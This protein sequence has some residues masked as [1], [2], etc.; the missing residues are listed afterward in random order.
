[1][2]NGREGIAFDGKI[3]GMTIKSD[4][5]MSFM[6]EAGAVVA[7]V[8]RS[9]KRAIQPGTKTRELDLIAEEEIDKLGAKS[10]FKGYT[11]GGMVPFPATIC[12]SVND[13]IVHG[14][15]SGRV[16]REGDL[17]SV[18]AGAMVN[19]FHGDSAFTVAVGQA[20]HD[21]SRLIDSTQEALM[22]GIDQV[23]IG[24]RVGDISA[25][26]QS[27]SEGLGYGVVRKYTG[28]G[29]GRSLHED[30]QVPNY[31]VPGRGPLLRSGMALAIEPMLNMGGPETVELEDGWT[32]A[33]ADGSLSA[34][35]EETIGILDEGVVEVFTSC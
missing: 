19:G 7:Q 27:Y 17:V 2:N 3:S 10:N 34:H 30:P 11:G 16:L 18:D 23:R 9:V 33:T 6:R 28:H 29:I 32:V 15:P 8:K 26:V 35:F 5:E 4:R 25:A 20:S 14:V 12:V 24:A 21:V 22:V 31:G 13:E 1:M